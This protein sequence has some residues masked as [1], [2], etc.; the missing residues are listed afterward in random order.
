MSATEVKFQEGKLQTFYPLST[1]EVFISKFM[2]TPRVSLV[3]KIKNWDLYN[4][5]Y[6]I[7]SISLIKSS[8]LITTLAP[9]H[10]SLVYE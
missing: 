2:L 9:K 3:S 1:T 7:I 6:L 8:S 10:F 5:S 4:N